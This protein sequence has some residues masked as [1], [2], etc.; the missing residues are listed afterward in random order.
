MGAA[1][2]LL[3]IAAAVVFVGWP[4]VRGSRQAAAEAGEL[5]NLQSE[6]ALAIEDIRELDFDRELGNLSVEDHQALR[7]Q[8][9][10]RAVAVLR[11]LQA[12]EGRI[13]EEIERAVAEVRRRPNSAS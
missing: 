6:R 3:A 10:R 7:D 9:K 1:L 8:S 2:A 11:Q 12:Q 13:D 4:L 5:S